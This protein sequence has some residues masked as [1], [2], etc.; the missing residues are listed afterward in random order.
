MRGI[1]AKRKPESATAGK[2]RK[3]CKAESAPLEINL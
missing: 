3:A 1:Q 2:S